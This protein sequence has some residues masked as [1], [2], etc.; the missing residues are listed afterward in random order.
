MKTDPRTFEI[1][2]PNGELI[3]VSIYNEERVKDVSNRAM[4]KAR[5]NLSNMNF[6]IYGELID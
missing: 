1:T 6:R 4:R 5:L 3:N 2:V